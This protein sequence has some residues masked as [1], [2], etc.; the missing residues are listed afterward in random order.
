MMSVQVER[1]V[2]ILFLSFFLGNKK[3]AFKL[4]QAVLESI[5][6]IA[7]DERVC[8]VP[9]GFS[10]LGRAHTGAGKPVRALLHGVLNG[11]GLD[12]IPS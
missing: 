5:D 3:P 2:F 12:G 9:H 4:Q 10:R 7:S 6:V 11:R 8:E 1:V